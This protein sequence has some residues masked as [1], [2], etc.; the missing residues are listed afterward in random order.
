[1]KHILMACAAIL[2]LTSLSLVSCSDSSTFTIKG[3]LAGGETQS[4]RFIYYSDNAL[5]TVHVAAR[6]GSFEMKGS[7]T[8]PTVVNVLANDGKIIARIYVE[9]GQTIECEFNRRAPWEIEMKGNEIDERWAAFIREHA[10]AYRSDDQAS[11]NH[12]VEDYVAAHPADILSTLLAVTTYSTYGNEKEAA[13]MLET[14]D[15][16]FRPPYLT[17]PLASMLA[18]HKAATDTLTDLRFYWHRDSFRIISPAMADLTLVIL[19]ESPSGTSRPDSIRTTLR[20]LR[21]AHKEKRLQIADLSVDTDTISWK[22]AVRT[23][24]ATWLQGWAQGG[25]LNEGLENF[26]ID[27]LPFFIV[28]DSTGKALYAGPSV[29]AAADSVNHRLK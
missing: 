18:R 16:D 14:I 28:A 22:R 17:D 9:N 15:E 2:L 29:V 7:S 26:A 25:I 3:T 6:E 19:S 20:S 8:R 11:L 24:S 23:D 13:D 4:M 21:K 10:D 5:H 1:M 27:E 12:I